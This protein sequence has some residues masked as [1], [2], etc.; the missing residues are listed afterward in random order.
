MKVDFGWLIGSG[1]ERVT[2]DGQTLQWL[3]SLTGQ[4]SL[5]VECPWQILAEGSVALASRDHGQEY[6]VPCPIDAAAKATALLANRKIGRAYPH[7]VTADLTLE[8]EGEVVLRTFNDSTGLEAWQLVG[9]QGAQCIAQGGGN[10]VALA[11][12]KA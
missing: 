1:V 12:D 8:L 4:A 2:Y 11:G 9:P 5:T 6:G 7:Q 3:F 10:I